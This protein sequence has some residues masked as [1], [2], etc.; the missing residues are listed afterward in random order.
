MFGDLCIDTILISSKSVI[1][2]FKCD[3]QYGIDMS[4]LCFIWRLIY[5][6]S[7]FRLKCNNANM[8][9][10]KVWLCRI[11][12]SSHFW[13]QMQKDD[14]GRA[15]IRHYFMC[16]IVAL[17]LSYIFLFLAKKRKHKDTTN[18]NLSS[19]RVFFFIFVLLYFEA[20]KWKYDMT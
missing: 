3:A 9:K 13:G 19:L 18:S 7:L 1:I 10:H 20:K 6:M 4:K 14:K 11:F 17:H 16:R 2:M 8:R 15:K 12:A 5:A